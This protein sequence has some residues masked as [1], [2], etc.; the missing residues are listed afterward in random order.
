MTNWF[1]LKTL[2]PRIAGA[3]RHPQRIYYF[4]LKLLPPSVQRQLNRISDVVN[5]LLDLVHP[6]DG[7]SRVH[8]ACRITLF[9]GLLRRS[10]RSRILVRYW[11]DEKRVI[12]LGD[13]ISEVLLNEMG[14]KV[15]RYGEARI[16]DISGCYASC[17]LVSGSELHKSMIDDISSPGVVVW[18]QGKGH[19][20]SFDSTQEPYRTKV[21]V[22]AVRGPRTIRQLK[23]D[24]VTAVGDPGLLLPVFFSIHKSAS[25]YNVAYLP[26]I[27]NRDHWEQKRGEVGADRY[28]DIMC[29]RSAFRSKLREIVSARLV[30]TNSMHGAIISQA[31]GVP[32]ALCLATGDVLN[33]PEKWADFFE[34]LGLPDEIKPVKN[35]AEGQKWWDEVGSQIPPFNIL[36]LLEA[37][38]L[39]IK[40]RQARAKVNDWRTKMSLR[41]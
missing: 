9:K 31:Y 21:Q 15:V 3:I 27:A 29:T 41:G 34:S 33:Y 26:H 22:A 1:S 19:G 13:Y 16:L 5:P 30:L 37:F 39:P 28:I 38:P 2:W 11:L 23:L 25:F 35:R 18:G 20:E 14:Y 4:G 6:P 7:D 36:P 10:F 12:N 32:W 17:W 40:D 24:P 8:L